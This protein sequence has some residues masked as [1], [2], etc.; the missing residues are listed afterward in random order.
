MNLII[1]FVG[2]LIF[3]INGFLL[4]SIFGKIFRKLEKLFLGFLLYSAIFTFTFFFF[5]LYLNTKYS[6]CS[7]FLI[8]LSYTVI[9]LLTN[10]IVYFKRK[11]YKEEKPEKS[12]LPSFKPWE[13]ILI[14]C[15][16]VYVLIP[17]VKGFLNPIS[18]WD[19]LVLYDFYGKVFA[20]EGIMNSTL[21]YGY[22]NAYPFY[23]HLMHTWAYLLGF[24]TPLFTHGL[25]Y[26]CF[27]GAIWVFLYRSFSSSIGKWLGIIA[28][29]GIGSLYSHATKG[30]NNLA[31]TFFL[32]LAFLMAYRWWEEKDYKFLILSAS[33][34]AA[35]LWCRSGEPWYL[36]LLIAYIL[37]VFKVKNISLLKRIVIIFTSIIILFSTKTAWEYSLS[38]WEKLLTNKQKIENVKK[39]NPNKN[40]NN[41]SINTTKKDSILKR[42]TNSILAPFG[43]LKYFTPERIIK[44]VPIAIPFAFKATVYSRWMY[45][46]IF[47]LAFM[48]FLIDKEIREN[49][50]LW[51]VAFFFIVN[52]LIIFVGTYIF[53]QN[54]RDWNIP[55]SAY[56]MSIFLE[57]LSII[58]A[59][60]VGKKVEKRYFSNEEV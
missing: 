30:Y 14:I 39:E 37:G 33:F 42:L 26:G 25:M 36:S 54:F 48:L 51:L 58:F 41:N 47:I 1:K 24:E 46:L 13:L 18:S 59:I 50:S 5:N 2:I 10:S 16:S 55:G 20:N 12:F 57:P 19:A 7:G 9:F 23:V 32:S 6:I 11:V 29:L 22:Y 21:K 53:I 4:F 45:F 3:F 52:T 17:I 38:N 28:L 40:D 31:P 60:L 43:T 8:H 35:N 34:G 27:I 15:I 56:R 44:Y 49:P